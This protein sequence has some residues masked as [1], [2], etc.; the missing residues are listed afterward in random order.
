[1]FL[2][3]LGKMWQVLSQCGSLV[4]VPTH[5]GKNVE[6]IVTMWIISEC[7]YSHWEKLWYPS[8]QMTLI[9]RPLNVDATS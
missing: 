2:L 1:M 3:T 8:G 6:S 7:S 4:N 9:Q 5:T